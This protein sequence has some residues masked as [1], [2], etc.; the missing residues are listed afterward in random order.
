VDAQI[1]QFRA[2]LI[3]SQQIDTGVHIGGSRAQVADQPVT[4]GYSGSEP[5]V[6]TDRRL[7]VAVYFTDR[8]GNHAQIVEFWACAAA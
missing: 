7:R 6:T 4:H 2:A 1:E 5:G 3:E 8:T